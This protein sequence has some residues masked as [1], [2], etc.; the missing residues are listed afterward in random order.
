MFDKIEI[1]HSDNDNTKVISDLETP[2]RLETRTSKSKFDKNFTQTAAKA[3]KM[4]T[5][6]NSMDSP[7][8]GKFCGFQRGLW[9]L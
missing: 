7:L 4:D 9:G 5:H 8:V 2:E 6:S 1:Y 3:R